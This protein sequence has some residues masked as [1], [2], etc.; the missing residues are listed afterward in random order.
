MSKRAAPSG[1]GGSP[2]R[3]VAKRQKRILDDTSRLSTAALLAEQSTSSVSSY[4]S[5]RRRPSIENDQAS[6]SLVS[7][8]LE[9][10]VESFE[11]TFLTAEGQL[12]RDDENTRN[13]IAW[14]RLLSPRLANS[15]LRRLMEESQTEAGA[16]LTVSALVDLF[17]RSKSVT[18]FV[19]PPLYFRAAQ[20][21]YDPG[22]RLEDDP[23]NVLTEAHGAHM[24]RKTQQLQQSA[25]KR[26]QQDR[27]HLLTA[28]GQCS[29][30]RSL[31]LAGQASLEDATCARMA[32]AL[33]SLEEIDLKGCTS[34]GDDTVIALARSAGKHGSLKILNLNFTAVTVKGLKSLFARCKSLEVLKLANINGLVRLIALQFISVY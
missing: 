30:L 10:I 23:E 24:D 31:V 1:F 15:L 12:R 26:A 21:Q 20:K 29:S 25:L 28:L 17:L 32:K 14:L 22:Q 9:V 16:R 8:C 6:R 18:S 13:S 7:I 2:A 5:V 19:L 34:V 4:L 33:S 3:S 11:A 27:S